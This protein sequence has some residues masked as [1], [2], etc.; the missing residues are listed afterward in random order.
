VALRNVISERKEFGRFMVDD[1]VASLVPE[2]LIFDE[3]LYQWA[4]DRLP[5]PDVVAYQDGAWESA[6]TMRAIEAPGLKH[7]CQIDNTPFF[8]ASREAPSVCK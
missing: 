6:N 8:I 4:A 5:N 2:T 1:A 3:W 7:R